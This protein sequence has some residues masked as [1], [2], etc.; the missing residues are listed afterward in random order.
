MTNRSTSVLLRAGGVIVCVGLAMGLFGCA[1]GEFRP[2]DPF[3]RQVTLHDA[4]HRYTVLMRWK[5]FDKARAFVAS[6]DRA[7]FEALTKQLE[8]ARFTGYESDSPELDDEKESAT[9][10]VTYTLWLPSQPYETEIVEH[11]EWRRHGVT[12]DW[13][14]RSTFEDLPKVAANR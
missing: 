3:D 8:E 4:Q 12:N 6:E 7:A 5:H 10:R 13:R 2:S 9:L 14:V 1:Q 11:Q